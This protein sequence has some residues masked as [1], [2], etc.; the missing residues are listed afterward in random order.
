MTRELNIERLSAKSY[1]GSHAIGTVVLVNG[2]PTHF[3]GPSASKDANDFI[4]RTR[5]EKRYTKQPDA[6]TG[7]V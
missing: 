7:D 1:Y 6:A 5:H 3:T 2:N 4:R